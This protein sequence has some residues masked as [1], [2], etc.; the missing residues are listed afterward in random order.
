MGDAFNDGMNDLLAMSDNELY[1]GPETEYVQL[2]KCPIGQIHSPNTGRCIGPLRTGYYRDKQTNRPR[3]II[4]FV[5]T[6]EDANAL[7]L[8]QQGRVD[9]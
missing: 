9:E 5:A 3:K 7:A 6:L 8:E 1:A 4:R 2:K